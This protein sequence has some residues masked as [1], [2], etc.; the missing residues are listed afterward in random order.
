LTEA[1]QQIT[2]KITDFRSEQNKAHLRKN[3]KKKSKSALQKQ[4]H[5]LDFWFF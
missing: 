2:D 4:F 5:S 1:A 3:P